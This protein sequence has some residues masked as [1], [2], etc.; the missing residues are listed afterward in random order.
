MTS[1]TTGRRVGATTRGSWRKRTS[2]PRWSTRCRTSCSGCGTTK[3]RRVALPRGSRSPPLSIANQ[4]LGRGRNRTNL[5]RSNGATGDERLF[6]RPRPI[7]RAGFPRTPAGWRRTAHGLESRASL[8]PSRSPSSLD[9]YPSSARIEACAE[10]LRVLRSDESE[11]ASARDRVAELNAVP[12]LVDIMH[13]SL[14]HI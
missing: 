8:T 10:L 13:L 12:G 9:P 2:R 1:A 14:I 5:P 4:R 7:G 6:T 11:S 3:V